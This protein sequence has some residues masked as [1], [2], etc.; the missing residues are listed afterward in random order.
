MQ[1][2]ADSA[3]PSKM[4]PRDIEALIFDM[5]GVLC[6]TMPFHLEAWLQYSAS[7]PGLAVVSRDRLEQM[8]GKRNEE[9]LPELLGYPVSESDIQRWGAE[10]EAVYRD[11]I[12]GHIQFLPGLVEFL[13]QAQTQGFNLGLGTSACRENVELL[14]AHKNLGDFFEARVIDADVARGKP[15]PQCYLMVA[16][17]LG[18]RPERCLVFEDAVAGVEA[19]R[20]AGMTCWGVLT[21]YSEADLRQAGAE[22]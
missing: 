21:T 20:N 9:L 19:A 14:L 15:D 8:G 1:H 5:D 11:L 13:T 16:E 4:M 17:R 2:P 10:K 6:D 22:H 7:V 12:R 18:I 3:A